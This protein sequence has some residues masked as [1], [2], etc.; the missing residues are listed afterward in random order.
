MLIET[1]CRLNGG[2]V[3]AYQTDAESSIGKHNSKP[4]CIG[5]PFAHG[6]EEHSTVPITSLSAREPE[7]ILDE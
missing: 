7:T 2:A 3:A 5:V 4:E 1:P 6:T